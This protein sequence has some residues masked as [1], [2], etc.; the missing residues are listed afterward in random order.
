MVFICVYPFLLVKNPQLERTEGMDL[1]RFPNL[2]LALLPGVNIYIYRRGKSHGFR[3][4][5][6][7]NG[8]LSTSL[9]SCFAIVYARWTVTM[10]RKESSKSRSS[11][12]S[13]S[14]DA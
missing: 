8:G 9:H 13:K 6:C 14:P 1:S 2:A 7:L 5:I 10:E 4:M 3:N 11:R 12:R